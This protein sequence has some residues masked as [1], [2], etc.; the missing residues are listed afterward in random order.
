MLTNSLGKLF[1]YYSN[2][3]NYANQIK[4]F[5][6]IDYYANLLKMNNNNLSSNQIFLNNL[7]KLINNN[8]LDD[9]FESQKQTIKL[10]LSNKSTMKQQSNKK[11]TNFSVDALLGSNKF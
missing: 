9:P 8:I 2:L 10:D 4:V 11:L 3:A 5:N 6:S 1:T 7:N